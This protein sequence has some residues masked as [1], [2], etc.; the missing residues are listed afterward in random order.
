M[1]T[2]QPS[3]CADSLKEQQQSSPKLFEPRNAHYFLNPDVA[4]DGN[5]NGQLGIESPGRANLPEGGEFQQHG[6]KYNINLSIY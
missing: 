3:I 6:N 2:V 5:P 1:G 4:L